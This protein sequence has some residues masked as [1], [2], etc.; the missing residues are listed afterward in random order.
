MPEEGLF[1]ILDDN[2]PFGTDIMPP[3]D[4]LNRLVDSASFL[5]VFFFGADADGRLR[6]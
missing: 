2:P 3:L 4:A 5:A 1:C 6:V